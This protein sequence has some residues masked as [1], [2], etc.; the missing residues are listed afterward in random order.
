MIS[1][2]LNSAA[3]FWDQPWCAV[4]ARLNNTTTL[5][6]LQQMLTNGWHHTEGCDQAALGGGSRLLWLEF[7]VSSKFNHPIL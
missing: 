1:F 3:N 7:F 4:C 2:N 6:D 5:A